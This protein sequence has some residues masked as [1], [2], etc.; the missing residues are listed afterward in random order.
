MCKHFSS[1]TFVSMSWFQFKL[2]PPDYQHANVSISK[3]KCLLTTANI[4]INFLWCLQRTFGAFQWDLLW[5]GGALENV[6]IA[7]FKNIFTGIFFFWYIR[8]M[9]KMLKYCLCIFV[10]FFYPRVNVK[11]LQEKTVLHQLNDERPLGAKLQ[12]AAMK[13]AV[14][15]LSGRN[16]EGNSVVTKP[17]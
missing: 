14:T 10:I 12:T 8:N 4:W 16:Q 15:H 9:Y 7:G 6:V 1:L 2:R 3:P 5:R 13:T 11:C 17:H